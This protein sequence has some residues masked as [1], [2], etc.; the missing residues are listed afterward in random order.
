ME[1]LKSQVSNLKSQILIVGAGP[2][3]TSAAIRLARNGFR[4]CLIEREKFP[5]EKLCGE[6]ISP[7]CFAHFRELGVLDKMLA[8]GGD[9]IAKTVFYAPNGKSVAVPSQWFNQSENALGL[10]RAR[11]DFLLLERAA[12]LG[13]EVLQ[14]TSAVGLL[15]EN[16]KICGIKARQKNGET[17]E[18]AAD[19]TIDATGRANVLAKFAE[20][21]KL[22]ITNYESRTT[23][24]ELRITNYELQNAKIRTLHSA[25]R[26]RLV[27]FK[28]H[29]KNAEIERGRCEIYF[30][31]GGYGGLNLVENDL[32]NHCFLIRADVVREFGGDA[33]RIVRSVIFQ[34]K[35]AAETLRHAAPVYDWLAVA[36]DSFGLKGLNPASGVLAI[37][38]AGAFIDPFTGSGMLMALESGEILAR[39]IMESSS[40][41]QIADVYKNLHAQKFQKR[42]R[43]CSVMRRAAFVP[44]LSTFL[45]SALSTGIFPLKSLA[46]AT[47]PQF[48]I[49]EK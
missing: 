41:E 17:F 35:R 12:K 21:E 6:F 39:A 10:S 13:V 32:S 27:G 28:A 34:N 24:Y 20:K 29:L 16:G 26:N 49:S 4:V 38:D 33:E 47:R 9:S 5:R 8:A 44:N 19:L 37:G 46:R 23:N 1:N 36:I 42:L 18:I 11:M 14:E 22:R 3:G 15:F 48:S 31:R 40:A 2:A 7:E 30:F 43:I 45:I 25:F